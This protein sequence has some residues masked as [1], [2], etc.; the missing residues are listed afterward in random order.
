MKWV[1]IIL[2]F[3]LAAWKVSAQQKFIYS[4]HIEYERKINVHRQ[5]EEGWAADL[6]KQLP[7]FHS[8][9]F[10]L[11]FDSTQTHYQL[12]GD[13]PTVSYGWIVGPAKE[14]VIDRDM[15]KGISHSRKQVFEMKYLIDDSVGTM[16][17]KMTSE[18]RSIAGF[19]CRKAVGIICDSVYVVAFYTDE[20]PV[21]SGPES[22]NGLP[23]MILGIVIPRLYT[24]WFA[25]KVSLSAAPVS[26]VDIAKK[27]TRVKKDELRSVLL[28]TFKDWKDERDRYIW[29]IM[30]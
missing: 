2:I 28:S 18:T 20:I 6:V 24:T 8:S 1:S 10:S 15:S 12:S 5:S 29:W 3:G 9:I 30:L 13:L 4:G 17:W 21:S 14:N 11:D 27:G 7:Q 19:E 23:G 22:F 25:T 26:H 16:Q